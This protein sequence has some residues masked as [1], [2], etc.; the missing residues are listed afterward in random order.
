MKPGSAHRRQRYLVVLTFGLLLIWTPIIAYV[1][2]TPKGYTSEMSL[3]LPGAGVSTSISVSEIGQATSNSPSAYGSSSLSPTVTYKTLL[4]SGAV[5]TRAAEAIGEPPSALGKPVIKL[6]SETSLINFSLKGRTPE[7]AFQRVQAVFE[8]FQAELDR[9]RTDEIRRREVS[10]RAVIGDYEDSVHTIR[11]EIDRLQTSSGLN[12]TDQYNGIIA[13]AEAL[14]TRLT[15]ARAGW[16][17]ATAAVDRLALSLHTT[18]DVA[19]RTIRLHADPEFNTLMEGLGKAAADLA[20]LSARYGSRHPLRVAAQQKLAGARAMA[21]R[22]AV[23]LTGLPEASIAT[24]I[25]ASATG[26]RAELLARLISA[27]AERDGKAAEL[28]SLTKDFEQANARVKSLVEPAA[29]LESLNRDYKIAEA[30]FASALAR[31]DTVKADIFASYPMTQVVE[32]ASLP[33]RP[34]SPKTLL[35]IAAGMAASIFLGIS[36]LLGSVRRTVIDKLITHGRK[37]GVPPPGQ[38]PQTENDHE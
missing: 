14:R 20:A 29:R 10:T 16:A 35:A 18:P 3:I 34:S 17:D 13:T 2:L 22:R 38:K 7:Q 25:D 26:N 11:T 30:V 5:L 28:D 12:S 36:L 1:V 6:V 21:M 37:L 27:G 24:E 15:E 33:D 8:A 32:P 4:T 9:L 31:V 19:A 23:A